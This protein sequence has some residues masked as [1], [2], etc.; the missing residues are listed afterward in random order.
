MQAEAVAYPEKRSPE[1]GKDWLVVWLLCALAATRVF[2]F[3]AVFPFFNNVDERS[4]FDLVMKYSLGQPPRGLEFNSKE[5]LP[6]MSLYPS[7]EFHAPP[8]EFEGGYF[9]PMWTHPAEE[10]EATRA[11]IEEIRA[12]TRNFQCSQM[13]LYYA[14]LGAWLNVGRALGIEGGY[15]L[16]WLRFANIGFIIALVWIAYWA[17]SAVFPV[18]R[19]IPLG[20]ATL[21]AFM[22]HDMFY[23]IENDVLSPICFGIAFVCLVRWWQTESS[24]IS[25]G[26]VTGLALASTYLTKLGNIPLL[27]VAASALLL[28]A[29]LLFRRARLGAAIPAYVVCGLCAAIPVLLWSLRMK[30]AFG[31]FTGSAA[32][33]ELM[34]WTRK[35]FSDWWSHPIFTPVGFWTFI[36]ELIASF[37]RGGLSWHGKVMA[38][39]AI[40]GFYIVS[41]LL[42]LFVAI[43]AIFRRGQAVEQTAQFGL[44]LALVSFIGAIGFLG[45]L[46]IQ[47]DF[48]TCVKPSRAQPFFTSGRLMS[49]ALIPFLILYLYGLDR[50]LGRARPALLGIVGAI[51]LLMTASEISISRGAFSSV[52]N[53]FHLRDAS[54]SRSLP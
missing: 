19:A 53:L 7:P 10:I 27:V 14:L 45:L 48:G 24:R 18:N 37:W 23:S 44:W 50:L 36:S 35:P 20:A 16:Y 26:A 52:Y 6:Y 12:K 21:A 39:P 9:G 30:Q 33:I 47:F 43:F 41:T 15:L 5:S 22:P 34:T 17:A 31:D 25:L 46:S 28:R 8:Q 2:V 51:A 1:P 49:G 54:P 29:W 42:L 38:L 4:H 11:T 13:P 40:D 3:S 32:K